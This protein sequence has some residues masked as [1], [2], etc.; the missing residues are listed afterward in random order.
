MELAPSPGLHFQWS[1]LGVEAPVLFVQRVK[2]RDGDTEACVSGPF[3]IVVFYKIEHDCIAT[4]AGDISVLPQNREAHLLGEEFESL[5]KASPGRNHGC[6]K[7]ELAR[8]TWPDLL[9]NV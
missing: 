7:G 1:H 9:R 4:D 5:G 6:S 8:S 3:T 2:I